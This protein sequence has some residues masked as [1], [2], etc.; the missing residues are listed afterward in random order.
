MISCLILSLTRK[1]TL[2]DHDDSFAFG[3]HAPASK[4]LR[5]LSFWS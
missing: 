4:V 2:G 1:R 3:P 5:W